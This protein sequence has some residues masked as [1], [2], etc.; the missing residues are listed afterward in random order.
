MKN[1]II[2]I[3]LLLLLA[4]TTGLSA[5][6]IAGS[7]NASSNIDT[8]T[9]NGSSAQPIPAN[10]FV[11]NTINNLKINNTAGVTLGGT[12]NVTPSTGGTFEDDPF[13]TLGQRSAHRSFGMS[14]VI[15]DG[16]MRFQEPDIEDPTVTGA[17]N[18]EIW[19]TPDSR[20]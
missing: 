12:L 5:Q 1:Y 3:Y 14:W 19:R 13:S 17:P 6:T 4:I 9:Y 20:R 7:I 2:Y 18:E 8:V 15:R 11:S 10:L 16:F